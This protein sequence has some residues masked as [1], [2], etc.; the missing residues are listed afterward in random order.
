MLSILRVT[1]KHQKGQRNQISGGG[2]RGVGD[3]NKQSIRKQ[4]KCFQQSNGVTEGLKNSPQENKE[5]KTYQGQNQ[6]FDSTGI[7]WK[8]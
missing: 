2:G 5:K 4:T 1:P 8:L 7:S 6:D 3:T